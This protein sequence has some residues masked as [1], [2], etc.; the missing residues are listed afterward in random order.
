[1]VLLLDTSWHLLP[2]QPSLIAARLCSA[3]ALLRG[4]AQNVTAVS[5]SEKTLHG[6]DAVEGQGFKAYRGFTRSH[7][8]GTAHLYALGMSAPALVGTWDVP[9]A[10]RLLA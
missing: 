10:V 8:F 5:L 2:F 7:G 1:M 3:A 9:A 4:G 6:L